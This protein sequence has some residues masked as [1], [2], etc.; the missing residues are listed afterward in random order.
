MERG[1]WWD[2]VH[3]VAK[4]LTGLKWL[5]TH[6]HVHTHRAFSRY[7]VNRCMVSEWMNGWANEGNN[8]QTKGRSVNHY[9][10]YRELLIWLRDGAWG[11][12]GQAHWEKSLERQMRGRMWWTIGHSRSWHCIKY[13]SK[14][15]LAPTICQSC[16]RLW[17]Y[18]IWPLPL[19]SLLLLWGILI[20]VTHELW[21]Q[22]A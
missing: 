14:S 2:T 21:I 22:T 12:G 5:N 11:K 3:R 10:L 6:T 19:W 18:K 9:G 13:I 20:M 8:E 17:G 4:S 15:L 16:V 1:A 7:S